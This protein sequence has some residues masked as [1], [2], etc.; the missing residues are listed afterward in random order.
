MFIDSIDFE[1]E[2]LVNYCILKFRLGDG[3]K[4][5]ILVFREVHL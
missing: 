1:C 3:R 4:L 5:I 2:N